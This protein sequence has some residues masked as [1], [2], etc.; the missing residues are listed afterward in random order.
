[1]SLLGS[2][3]LGL[4]LAAALFSIIC[5]IIASY[6]ANSQAI[7]FKSSAEQLKG[8]GTMQRFGSYAVWA[9]FLL[10]TICCIVLLI[11][12][13]TGDVTLDYVVKYRSNSTSEL[14]ALYKFSGLWAGRQGS[15]LFW[16]WLIALFSSLI[17]L[18]AWKK[19]AAGLSKGASAATSATTVNPKEADEETEKQSS[20]DKSALVPSQSPLEKQTPSERA[21][22]LKTTALDSAALAIMQAVL[23]L[24]AILLFFDPVNNPFTPINP[25]YLD[26]S[27]NLISAASSLGLNALLEHWAMVIH[28]PTLFVGYAGLTV[29]FAYALAALF[30]NDPSKTWV[31]RATRYTLISWLFLGAG[32][33]LGAIWAYV[34]LGWGGYWGWDPVENAS[35]LP[36]L[37]G[38]ALIHCMTVYR[39]HGSFKRWTVLCACLTFTFVIIATF[40]PRSGLFSES[41]VHSFDVNLLSLGLFGVLIAVSAVLGIVGL[42]LR[43]Q[44]FAPPVIDEDEEVESL[45]SKDVAYFF[46]SFILVFCTFLLFFMT[47]MANIPF[48]G[49]TLDAISYNYIARVVGIIY[50]LVIAICP[51]LGWKK[52]DPK[53]F[54]KRARIPGVC[55]L[56]V[57]ALLCYFFATT[58]WPMYGLTMAGGG[59]AAETLAKSGPEA[60]YILITIVGFFT[61]S[62]LVF[63]SLFMVVRALA[64]RNFRVQTIGGFVAHLGMGVML[65]GLIGSSMYVY[66]RSGY[67]PPVE[68]SAASSE[69]L[70]VEDY[71]LTYVSEDIVVSENGDDVFYSVTFDV[72]KDGSYLGQV[73][74]S[75]QLVQSTGQRQYHAAVLALPTED[76][77]VVY[78]GVNDLGAFSLNVKINPLIW[79][80]WGGFGLLM[81]GSAIAAFGRRK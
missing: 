63:N 24:F 72:S 9:S 35:L 51:L 40:I 57:F 39:Q 33:G 61:A 60:Y 34:V 59:M 62:L 5:L 71:A 78:N 36:W 38:V 47:V 49:I 53:A 80:V 13:F 65:V 25:D 1:M 26:A 3:S 23:S 15:L 37:M 20:P 69:P 42:I 22:A 56:A 68:A 67:I 74:P 31:S 32:I 29:P 19:S 81:A 44:S 30:V 50:F 76:F 28:P 66:E 41:S 79:F 10:L 58:L 73:T 54:W 48:I 45:A 21:A 17:A 18:K 14:A 16:A 7:R 70:V 8:I 11:C 43:S 55:A 12:F 2:A 52:T 27:G 64:K 6:R 4:A 77:F 75:L 46:N